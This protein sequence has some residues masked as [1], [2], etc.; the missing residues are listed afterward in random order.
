[1]AA[2]C[3]DLAPASQWLNNA[4][5][6]GYPRYVITVTD[7]QHPQQHCYVYLYRSTTLTQT[8][9]R[10]Y[11]NY[12]AYTVTGGAYKLKLVRGNLITDHLEL[13][14]NGTNI[15]DRTK[16]R[17]QQGSFSITEADLDF[18][19]ADG[20][21]RLVHDGLVRVIIQFSAR[22]EEGGSFI[23]LLTLTG[24][25]GLFHEQITLDFS[26]L[27]STFDLFRY[28]ADLSAAMKS[29]TYYD[30]NT[31]SGVRVDGDP[32]AV[33]ATPLSPW[34]QASHPTLGTIVQVIDP[35]PLG[36][37]PE[38]YYKDDDSWDG[39]DTGDHKS[40]ADPGV[41]VRSANANIVFQAWYYALGPGQPNVGATYAGYATHPL[42]AE[43]SREVY[44]S[45][46]TPTPGH[47]T[48]LP[49]VTR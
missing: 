1:M 5:A 48:Y 41:L 22:E 20:D 35:S 24:Y 3:G 26:S 29:A 40:Y 14:G 19:E 33:P 25:N 42:Q 44:S 9:T 21:W 43:T 30:A 28:S 37:T 4:E 39:Q 38:T 8:V 16:V 2:D 7:P 11:V 10:D 15:L 31:P 47:T 23:T 18:T 36:G 45:G 6:R 27:L 17:I 49:L 46:A 12:S 13:N 32:D 34:N